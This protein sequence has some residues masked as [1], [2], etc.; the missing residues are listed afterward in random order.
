[1]LAIIPA[2]C[3]CR[4]LFTDILLV[5]DTFRVLYSYETPPPICFHLYVYLYLC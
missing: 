3:G 2:V 1:M 4:R 5:T